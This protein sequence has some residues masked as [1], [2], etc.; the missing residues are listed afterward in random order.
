[1]FTFVV[2]EPIGKTIFVV[3]VVLVETIVHHLT[4]SDLAIDE[5]GSH[6]DSFGGQE[7]LGCKKQKSNMS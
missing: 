2:E 4:G 3:E 5:S 6:S 1:M 7:T